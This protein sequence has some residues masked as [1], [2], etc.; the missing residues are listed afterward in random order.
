MIDVD[1]IEELLGLGFIIAWIRR[2]QLMRGADA[3]IEQVRA[4]IG[5]ALTV[6]ARAASL[7]LSGSNSHK[8]IRHDAHA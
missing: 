1:L 7:T 2:K 6:Y 4:R 3:G 5:C 8:R